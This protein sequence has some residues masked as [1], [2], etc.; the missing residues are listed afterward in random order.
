MPGAHNTFYGCS[1]SLQHSVHAACNAVS[2]YDAV[3]FRAGGYE[4]SI[5]EA[6]FSIGMMLGGVLLSVAASKWKDVTYISL[7][8]VGIGAT[9]LA[10]GLLGKDAFGRRSRIFHPHNVE[11]V[12]LPQQPPQQAEQ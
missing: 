12:Q 6:V 2:F 10:S 9:C 7:S 8:L 11:A 1:G 4:A 3:P 5:V